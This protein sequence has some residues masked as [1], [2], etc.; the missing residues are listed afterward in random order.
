[1]P[2]RV[3]AAR[4]AAGVMMI[5][6]PRAGIYRGVRGI[7][8]ARETEGMEDAIIA[9]IAGQRLYPPPEGGS[10]LGFL[11]AAGPDAGFVE[12]VL[13]RAHAKLDFDIAATLDI[14]TR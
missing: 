11:F 2:E 13:R 8:A 7:E 10:Y 1:M 6:I 14:I 3:E 5:P 4:A 12:G 9:A